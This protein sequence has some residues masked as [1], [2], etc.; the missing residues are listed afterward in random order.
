MRPRIILRYKVNCSVSYVHAHSL[1]SCPTLCE[2]TDCKPLVSSIHGILHAR[3]LE[4]VALL[5]GIFQTQ[6]LNLGLLQLLPCRQIFSNLFNFFLIF[7][8]YFI[9]IFKIIL[10]LILQYCIGFAIYQHESA[11]GIF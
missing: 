9:C 11:T 5:Q 10:V 8:N 2:P 1:E 3:I 6:R 7:K 4:W